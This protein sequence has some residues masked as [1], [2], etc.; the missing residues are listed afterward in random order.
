MDNG[1]HISDL[2]YKK[3]TYRY[4][5][6]WF[7]EYG[8]NRIEIKGERS[9][10]F[11]REESIDLISN[12]AVSSKYIIESIPL[13]DLLD[14]SLIKLESDF[15][16][17]SEMTDLLKKID[18]SLGY[19]AHE[20][21]GSGCYADSPCSPPS[22]VRYNSAEEKPGAFVRQYEQKLSD[23][24]ERVKHTPKKHLSLVKRLRSRFIKH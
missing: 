14:D 13:K 16:M 24:Y 15:V 4:P 2:K 6:N 10:I 22:F 20:S 17:Q 1:Y 9:G 23:Y 21:R 7:N 8:D 18:E 3:Y 11:F 5:L 19:M 12:S